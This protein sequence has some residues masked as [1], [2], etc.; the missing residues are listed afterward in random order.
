MFCT[1]AGLIN[2]DYAAPDG[3]FRELLGGKAM[4]VDE[5]NHLSAN[6]HALFK[7]AKQQKWTE[8]PA[9]WRPFLGTLASKAEC[10]DDSKHASVSDVLVLNVVT[11]LF[12]VLLMIRVRS[13]QK[14]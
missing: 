9:A 11:Y 6:F 5:H 3:E 7:V 13:K 14:C 4:G 12:F 1:S 2:P 10:L 8:I